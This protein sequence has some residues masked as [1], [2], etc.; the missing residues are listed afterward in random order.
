MRRIWA[1]PAGMLRVYIYLAATRLK[2]SSRGGAMQRSTGRFLTTHT[3]SL[4][5]PGTTLIGRCSPRRKAC[6]WNRRRSPPGARAVARSSR[7]QV[8]AGIDLVNDGEM[9]K[10]SY[11]TYIKDRLDGFGGTA[12][13][14]V[15]QDLVDFPELARARVRRSRPRAAQDAGLQRADQRQGRASAPRATSPISSARALGGAGASGFMS[16]ASPGVVSLFFRNDYY[17]SHEAYIY[18][19]AEAMRHEYEADRQGRVRAADRLPRPRHGPPHPV[20]PI[21][22]CRSSASARGCMSRR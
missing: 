7:K 1:S 20:S 17:P 16:A 19:I 3:G 4:P 9:S 15:Y 8:E 6:R 5:R 18:A 2:H 13:R 14:F 10:P 12:T 21:S 11:A 22:T